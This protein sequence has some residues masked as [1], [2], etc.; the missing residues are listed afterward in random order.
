[1]RW[2]PGRRLSVAPDARPAN[3][4][5]P[6]YPIEGRRGVA[7][8]LLAQQA[9]QTGSR[10]LGIEVDGTG[11]QRLETYLG[12]GQIEPAVDFQVGPL[13]QQL[14]KDLRQQTALGKILGADDDPVLGKRRCR[15]NDSQQKKPTEQASLLPPAR[16]L[17]PSEC[18]RRFT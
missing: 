3:E 14:G 16:H 6:P 4:K 12:P 18:P 1:M 10:V 13:L 17:A 7:Q 2:R 5:Q 15:E 8:R 11:A 9:D